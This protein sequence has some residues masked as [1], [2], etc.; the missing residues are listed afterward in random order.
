MKRKDLQPYLRD[1]HCSFG[2]QF[3]WTYLSLK[4]KMFRALNLEI[5][6]HHI[7]TQCFPTSRPPVDIFSTNTTHQVS[8][9]LL[10]RAMMDW[11]KK[12]M[13]SYFYC[14]VCLL[15]GYCSI[16]LACSTKTGLFQS[17]GPRALVQYLTI[18]L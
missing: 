18:S 10:L 5:I 3:I 9:S 1:I 17:L 14:S 2:K 16:F 15:L 13:V 11:R 7:P 8:F 6:S 12:K 4:V